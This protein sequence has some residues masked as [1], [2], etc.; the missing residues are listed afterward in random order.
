M[1]VTI[2]PR[3]RGPPSSGNG[4]YSCGLLAAFLDA[5]VEVTLR[6]PPPLGVPL[7]VERAGDAAT[8]WHGDTRIA[9]ARSAPFELAPPPPPP[10]DA[11]A[12]AEA[13]YRGLHTHAFPGCFTCG[14]ARQ[15]GDGLRLFSGP[16]GA[17]T[18][19]CTWT[20][21]ASLGNKLGEVREPFLWAA[22]DCPGYWANAGEVAVTAVLGR[23]AARFERPLAVGEPCVVTGW[24]LGVDGRKR[25]AGT[26]VW[27]RDGAL[28]GCARQTWI[29]VRGA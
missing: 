28:V 12:A 15:A 27:T 9:D 16:V 24:S 18:V 11:A 19:A 6:T 22:L 4:G 5:P 26:A 7:R 21:D 2:D 8:L 3:F 25:H 29:E 20:P 13:Q 23:M 10:W 1:N 14:P 17:G